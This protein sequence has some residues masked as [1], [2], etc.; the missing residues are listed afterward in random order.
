M[1]CED[2]L[3]PMVSWD[4]EGG[5]RGPL[6]AD[7]EQSLAAIKRFSIFQASTLHRSLSQISRPRMSR[8][9]LWAAL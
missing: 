8:E 9:D 4:L 6:Q 7:A 1:E 5:R 2:I 3:V